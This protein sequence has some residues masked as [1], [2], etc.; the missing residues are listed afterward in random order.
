MPEHVS[1][2]QRVLGLTAILCLL[3]A[4]GTTPS[5][6]KQTS[7]WGFSGKI[8][9]WAYGEQESAKVDWQDCDSRY[10]VRLSGP[11]GVGGAIVYGDDSGVSLHRGGDDT[12]HAD[13]PEALLAS[14]GWYL[15]V[16]LLRFW[17]KGAAS[18]DAP[19]QREPASGGDITALTQLGWHIV[20]SYENENITRIA[21]DDGNIRLKW[22]IRNWLESVTCTA[23]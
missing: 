6:P 22:I 20:Y 14:M 2:A 4:C 19:Y 5:Q 17:L 15:P 13:S 21:M 9:L 10:L 23:P 3:S 11:L 7:G 18:P 1:L 16:S 8:G 12:L